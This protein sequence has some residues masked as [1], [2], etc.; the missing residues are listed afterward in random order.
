MMEDGRRFASEAIKNQGTPGVK[1]NQLGNYFDL[2]YPPMKE[3]YGHWHG[4]DQMFVLNLVRDI[5]GKSLGY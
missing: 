3:L 2:I 1:V 5:L 4:F